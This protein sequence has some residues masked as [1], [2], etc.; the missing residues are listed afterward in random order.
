MGF[1]AE[2]LQKIESESVPY[3]AAGAIPEAD[4]AKIMEG[5]IAQT[6]DIE[7]VMKEL[8]LGTAEGTLRGG[9][10]AAGLYGGARLGA[11]T[12][13]VTGMAGPV[14]GGGLGLVYGGMNAADALSNLF[15]KATPGLEPYREGA[16]TFG[17]SLGMAPL[18][19]AM[20]AAGAGSSKVAQA[21]S[22]IGEYARSHPIGYLGKEA[23]SAFYSGLAGGTAVNYAPE[24]PGTR[25]AAEI[26][27]GVLSPGKFLF[28]V[29]D[30]AT[31]ALEAGQKAMTPDAAHVRVAN[32]LNG[33]V[34]EA[35]EDPQKLIRMLEQK[36]PSG[37][38]VDLQ[39]MP[40]AAQK[41]ES[42]V[43]SALERSLIKSSEQ[44]A[45]QARGQGEQTMRAYTLLIDKLQKSGDP[46]ALK[47]A[48]ELRDRINTEK[49]EAAIVAAQTKALDMATRLGPARSGDRAM[50]G[51][52]LNDTVDSALKDARAMERDLW[53]KALRESYQEVSPAAI[54]DPTT[55]R[56][57]QEGV[58]K[59]PL[60]AVKVNPE[61]VVKQ[62][63]DLAATM[64]PERLRSEFGNLNSAMARMGV[65]K[66]TIEL[67]KKGMATREFL[68]TGAMPWTIQSQINKMTKAM[69]VQDIIA[70]RSDLL[71][72]ARKAE[73]SGDTG[74]ATI[75]GK[76]AS[77]ALDDMSTLPGTGY[78]NARAFSRQL[79][80][81]F[82]R[83]FA[84]DVGGVTRTGAERIP[85]E[86]LV[87]KAFSGGA[88]QTFLRMQQ[89]EDAVGMMAQKYKDAVKTYGA[90]SAQAKALQPYAAEASK[91]VNTVRD[92]QARILRMGAAET[93]NPSTG[94]VDPARLDRFMKKNADMIQKAG[95]TQEFTDVGRAQRSFLAVQDQGSAVNKALRSEE[96]FASLL[97]HE[98]PARAVADV[99]NGKNPVKG[100]K[101]LVSLTAD[102]PQAKEG[103]LSTM[104]QYAFA[105]A[106]GLDNFSIKKYDDALFQPMSPNQ[107]SLINVMRANDLITFDQM[108][109]LR[110]LINPM[111]K[112][113]DAMAA[114]KSFDEISPSGAMSPVE[115]LVMSQ[116]GARLANVV[117]PKGPGSLSFAAKSIQTVKRLFNK[118]PAAQTMDLLREVSLD[119][120]MT[121]AMLKRGLTETEQRA[122]SVGILRR[123]Y[124][125]GSV[126]SAIARYL[127]SNDDEPKVTPTPQ[128][129]T[130]PIVPRR[131]APPAVPTRG[132]PHLD[133]GASAQ[134]AEPQTQSR[135]MF[136]QLF[137]TDPISS[138]I[139]PPTPQA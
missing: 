116:V 113:E 51:K 63:L 86:V 16:K 15:P 32:F 12:S 137:P 88:D 80:D 91:R 2:D 106:G 102:S 7:T 8:G 11:L 55:R 37:L 75:F 52:I 19:Y 79:N 90:N 31:K 49:L 70:L 85:P 119:P 131:P 21:I 135:A 20:P 29:K 26:T 104:Y 125:Q 94:L 9:A 138:M 57:V 69:P 100:I 98:D 108:K 112:V 78:D 82:T 77:S 95:L 47:T 107:P 87:S 132:L 50:V 96:A 3:S 44:Y 99:L 24:S 127:D 124:S 5:S 10:M 123:L 74:A 136:Q 118:M 18:G 4:R 65:N 101:S 84:N 48:A 81:V 130:K 34:T 46:M 128:A 28:D 105:K 115:D 129:P 103:L 35:G 67:Y 36:T 13:P 133:K 38:S 97:K 121:A 41:A 64:T 22:S 30:A 109:N 73:G 76:V 61:N 62:Y 56:L 43:L 122:L 58:E 17:E 23:L 71:D 134:P 126:N 25:A 114:G 14:V 72:A 60:T 92:A 66:E 120:E 110:R 40:T 111:R 6:H 33:L 39:P 59:A 117:M 93:I 68:D 89:V 53:Q 83:T 1:S 139:A 27:A 45:G 42:P 54:K